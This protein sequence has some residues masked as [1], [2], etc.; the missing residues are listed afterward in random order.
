M[1]IFITA[2]LILN[3]LMLAKIYKYHIVDFEG[4]RIESNIP[5]QEQAEIF[6]QFIIDR[7]GRTDLKIEKIH[8]PQ[9]D[10]HILGRDPDLH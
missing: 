3:N 5:D 1:N 8:S 10:G 2:V 4:N 6:L 7:D 9:L